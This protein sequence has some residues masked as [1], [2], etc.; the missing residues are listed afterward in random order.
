MLTLPPCVVL[1]PQKAHQ[2][3]KHRV[4][5]SL[6]PTRG[7]QH[8]PA[9]GG[10]HRR[11]LEMQYHGPT[12]TNCVG[13]CILTRSSRE[14]SARTVGHWRCA[15]LLWLVTA[16]CSGHLLALPELSESCKFSP[17]LDGIQ[18]IPSYVSELTSTSCIIQGR[19]DTHPQCL[20]GKG[21]AGHLHP[22]HRTPSHGPLPW[23]CC[24]LPHWSPPSSAAPTIACPGKS[25]MVLS[26]VAVF[27]RHNPV[28]SGRQGGGR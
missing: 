8:W 7:P 18:P 12:Q 20:E 13:V 15:K 28:T 19:C 14:V 16:T 25:S 4:L 27:Q 9:A 1:D 3:S 24:L 11:S 2:P 26:T 5:E 22:F 17:D 21:A 23:V 6:Y 10:S